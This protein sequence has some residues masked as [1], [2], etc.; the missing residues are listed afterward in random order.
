MAVWA[1]VMTGQGVGAIATVQ[2]VGDSAEE[3]LRQ[4]FRRKDGR[5]FEFAT[6]RVLLGSI[7]EKGEI[8]DEVTVGCEGPGTFALHCHGNPLLVARIIEML[9][10]QGVQTVPAEQLLARMLASRNAHNAIS[11]EAKLA[12]TT[13]KTIE[14]ATIITNQVRA[15]LSEKIRQWQAQLDSVPLERITAEAQAILKHS[16]PAHLII[17]GCTIVLV[18]PP[19][20]GKSTLLNTL[21]GREKAIVS[22]VRGTTR[23]WVSA[24]IHLP[25][26]AATIIDTAGLDSLIPASGGI[27]QVAQQKTGAMIE[28]ADLVLLVLDSSQSAEPLSEPILKLVADRRTVTVLNK[29]DLSSRFDP[30][31]LPRAL[32]PVIRISAKQ[33]AGIDGL[34]HAIHSAC[35]VAGFNRYAPV[36]FTDRQRHLLEAL[37]HS[38]SKAQ[39]RLVLSEFMEDLPCV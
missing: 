38:G 31:S 32:M 14:G 26:L 11:I 28:Q 12:L 7:V 29:A 8:L 2:L 25:P 36:A 1:A 35:G 17:S 10:K 9:Q 19:N 27:D 18:G 39:A 30:A 3:I 22:D 15:G 21:A 33:G 24:E 20:T 37:E 34:T 13:V 6:R 23:D 5:A 16:E 4:I